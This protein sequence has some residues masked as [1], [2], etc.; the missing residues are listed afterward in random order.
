MFV[1]KKFLN[2]S[3]AA[4]EAVSK[5]VPVSTEP[6][7]C[8]ASEC[9]TR[10]S[11]S[12]FKLSPAAVSTPLWESAKAPELHLLVSTG[13]TDWSHDAFDAPNT[14]LNK[15]SQTVNGVI[16]KEFNISTKINTTSL[17][18]N[19]D[20]FEAYSKQE[21]C[22]VLLMP[23]FVWCKGITIE[24]CETVLKDLLS[25]FVNQQPLPE[26]LHGCT[27][28][29]D[30]SKSYILLCSHRTRDKKCGITAPIMKK[31]FDSQL[32]ELEL[33]R[34][35]GDD[36]PGGVPVIFVNHVGGHKFAANVLIYNR[37]G[38]FVW[39]GRCT[40]LNVKPILQETIGKGKVFPELVR[41]AR[42]YAVTW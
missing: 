3:D 19:P 37:E 8:D 32:R 29:R 6:A 15:I 20:D 7:T 10:Y 42:K 34:D 4:I 38:E 13:K 1:L 25:A 9:H 33:Y 5:I 35:P 14:V 2:S 21:K 30:Y 28:E 39:F 18:L 36:R 41:N 40:P 31:E 22:D 27:I 11:A 12:C 16:S 24:N 17:A 23:Y 26:S